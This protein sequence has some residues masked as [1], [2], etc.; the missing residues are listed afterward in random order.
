MSPRRCRLCHAAHTRWNA[1]TRSCTPLFPVIAPTARYTNRCDHARCWRSCPRWETIE[2]PE[3]RGVATSSEGAQ[4]RGTG[5]NREVSTPQLSVSTRCASKPDRRKP[6]VD[7]S[8]V[9][10]TAATSVACRWSRT[11][12]TEGG[13]C[14]CRMCCDTT[15][16]VATRQKRVTANNKKKMHNPKPDDPLKKRGAQHTQPHPPTPLTHL[17][18]SASQR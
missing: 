5:R 7:H 15:P 11:E 6:R 13:V 17:S 8:L 18:M 2:A 14:R 1:V 10:Q 16:T 4:L 12:G 3:D 9:L